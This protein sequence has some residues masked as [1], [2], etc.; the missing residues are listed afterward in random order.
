MAP[1]SGKSTDS[2]RSGVEPEGTEEDLRGEILAPAR[3]LRPTD[4][5]RELDAIAQR[6]GAAGGQ[7][8]RLLNAMGTQAERAL[9][10]LPAPVQSSLERATRQALGI[11]LQGAGTSRRFW[12]DQPAQINRMMS[13]GLGAFGG[14]AG[15]PGVLIELP[16][17]TTLLLR[18]IQGVAAEHGFDPNAPSL[19]FDVLDVFSSAGPLHHD[20]GADT[21]FLTQRIGLAAGG[22]DR[23]IA[24][25]AP[26]LAAA[27]GP[28]VAAQLVPLAGAV[29]GSSINYIYA[30]YYQEMAHVHFGLRRL[31]IEADVPHEEMVVRL[32]LRLTAS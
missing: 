17:T 4:I 8:V 22:L 29:T 15:L 7:A 1:R 6:Y 10:S 23:M 14:A 24:L 21:S 27:F 30:G 2:Q 31:A 13:A 20:D 28:K 19:R 18:A 26:R 32:E 5:D 9:Q 3:L 16:L 11:A 12:P 25:V